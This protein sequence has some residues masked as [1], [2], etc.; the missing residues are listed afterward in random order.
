[1]N[2]K[3]DIAIEVHELTVRYKNGFTALQ[4]TSFSINRAP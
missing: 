4:N 2:S 1:M 3:T